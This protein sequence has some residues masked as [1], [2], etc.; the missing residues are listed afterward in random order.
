MIKGKH[1]C[2]A[3]NQKYRKIT[4]SFCSTL[5]LIAIPQP[6]AMACKLAGTVEQTGGYYFFKGG[7]KKLYSSLSNLV[8]NSPLLIAYSNPGSKTQFA[9]AVEK[10][11]KLEIQIR[12]LNVM[13]LF[14]TLSKNMFLSKKMW[15]STETVLVIVLETNS[16]LISI[17]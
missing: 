1:K 7:N 11:K 17:L 13:T 15:E 3:S 12:W 10:Q 9:I 4:L 6:T 14:S 5:A 16:I 2:F 8:H